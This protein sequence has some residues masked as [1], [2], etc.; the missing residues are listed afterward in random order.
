MF[1]GMGKIDPRKMQAMMKQMG[2]NQKEIEAD[3]VIIES[4]DKKIIIENP[5][6]QK[7]K[8]A[9][10]ESFQISGQVRE[11]EKGFSD[12]DISLVAERTGKSKSEAKKALE[13]TKDIAEAILK[14]S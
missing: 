7:I 14:L 13:E 6:I 9:G 12:E 1:P 11:E 3:R 8:M 5:S 10:Q 4:S 2:I